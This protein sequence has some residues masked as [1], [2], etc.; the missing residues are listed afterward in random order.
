MIASESNEGLAKFVVSHYKRGKLPAD[1]VFVLVPDRDPAALCA[2]R[3]Y[4]GA[5]GDAVLAARL[6][7]WADRVDG[8]VS[9]PDTVG[10]VARIA[11]WAERLAREVE[12]GKMSLT[13][14]LQ[15]IAGHTMDATLRAMRGP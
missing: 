3:A 13:T 5:T 12:E 1:S 2:L 7:Q 4:A 10:V 11:P 6:R 8:G 9:P 15:R 14:A